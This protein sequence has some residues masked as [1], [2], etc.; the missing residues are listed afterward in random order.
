MELTPENPPKQRPLVEGIDYYIE[1]GRWVFTKAYLLR[2]GECCGS[3]CRHCPYTN[4]N[5]ATV[6]E[7]PTAPK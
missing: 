5:T 1:A 4:S 3:K 6:A 2:R 7:P